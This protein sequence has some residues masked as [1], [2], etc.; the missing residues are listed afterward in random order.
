MIADLV[1]ALM[2][3]IGSSFMLL[4]A[5]GILR[6]P[7]LLI[8]MHASTKAGTVGAGLVF[9]GI[10]LYFGDLGIT[11]R[12]VV[13]VVFLLLT[14]PVGAH[15]IGRAAYFVGVSLWEGTFVDELKKDRKK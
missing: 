4:A 11:T 13:A 14:A 8:R 1:S 12:S 15:V 7:D 2:L 9:T 6:M 3:L 5:I 10:A